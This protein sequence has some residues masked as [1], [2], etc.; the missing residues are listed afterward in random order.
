MLL[1]FKQHEL[2]RADFDDIW[3]HRIALTKYC[4]TDN[5]IFLHNS[6]M[7]LRGVGERDFYDTYLVLH[8]LP[9]SSN[10]HGIYCIA[11]FVYSIFVQ[12]NVRKI[13]VFKQSQMIFNVN[14]YE[15]YYWSKPL[16]NTH[17]CKTI[18]M[19]LISLVK[20]LYISEESLKL[21]RLAHTPP[22]M[23]MDRTEIIFFYL[24]L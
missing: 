20:S 8:P 6:N 15:M 11:V 1:Y 5:Q 4:L 21:E 9:F 10:S 24:Y 14:V 3:T 18:S 17:M 2:I 13:T 23:I 16:I 22:S 19:Q 7:I 12:V